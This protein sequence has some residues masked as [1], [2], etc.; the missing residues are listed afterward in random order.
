LQ[1]P[2]LPSFLQGGI[3]LDPT[4]FEEGL[5]RLL[6]RRAEVAATIEYSASS[7]VRG[8]ATVDLSGRARDIRQEVPFRGSA[9]FHASPGFEAGRLQGKVILRG[10]PLSLAAEWSGADSPDPWAV[11]GAVEQAGYDLTLLKDVADVLGAGKNV[12]FS[13]AGNVSA[14]FTIR[15]RGWEATWAAGFRD[16]ALSLSPDAA[17]EGVTFHVKGTA[18]GSGSSGPVA[19]S[20]RVG[21]D[22]GAVLL[23]PWFF[24]LTQIPGNI[25]ARGGYSE[26]VL[27]IEGLAAAAGPVSL[28]A[29]GLP[30]ALLPMHPAELL[31]QSGAVPGRLRASGPVG[32]PFRILLQE[33]FASRFGVL[34]SIEPRGSWRVEVED[35]VLQARI[36][37]EVESQEGDGVKGVRVD[38]GYGGS[39][40]ECQPGKIGWKEFQ[41]G[42]LALGANEIP[43]TVCPA[44]LSAGPVRILLA[45]G[46]LLLEGAAWDWERRHL[47][48]EGL[49]LSEIELQ[50]LWPGSPLAARVRGR[51]ARGHWDGSRLQLEGEVVV[52]VA[53]GE[54]RLGRL[55]VEPQVPLPRFGADVIF[56][57]LDLAALTRIGGF[58]RITGRLNGR[59]EDLILSGAQP[60]A[61]DL[62]IESDSD[63]PG[64]RTISLE[65]VEN[66]AIL[67]GGGAIPLFGRM[68]KEFSY[69]R[70]G[71]SCSL[72]ND[73][74]TLR[75]LISRD[76]KEYLV[77]RGFWS[78]VNVIN[79]NPEGRISFRDMLERLQ[80]IGEG[81]DSPPEWR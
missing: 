60:E 74:F 43:L 63:A 45:P 28:R 30:P 29:E 44:G 68:F 59:I 32:L 27:R 66:I 15:P 35:G 51:I 16:F 39:Q 54:V 14:A 70:I 53:D 18:S 26:E 79:R 55:W 47:S 80:R 52:S 56:D 67:G 8:D 57:G 42:S 69:R 6:P 61:F 40:G 38:L 34:R 5:G 25:E 58:G 62:V 73:V 37:A 4:E 20:G 10:L 36:A 75:G 13:G 7:G 3:G 9:E 72:R 24:D 19:W 22:G 41:W 50:S 23:S 81:E 33:P 1:L 71:I 48:L 2:D 49:V 11:T 78:G 12:T 46:E 31:G 65:A 77:E 17:C 64:P 21:W 76:G